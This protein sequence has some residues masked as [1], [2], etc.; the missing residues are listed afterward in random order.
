MK[1]I[2]LKTEKKVLDLLLNTSLKRVIDKNKI[3]NEKNPCYIC[4]KIHLGS[5]IT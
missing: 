3:K 4:L 2:T 1:R 5:N